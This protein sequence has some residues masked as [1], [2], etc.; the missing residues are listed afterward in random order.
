MTSPGL[1]MVLQFLGHSLPSVFQQE[2]EMCQAQW[3]FDCLSV[4][5]D[6][7]SRSN[8]FPNKRVV[9]AFRLATALV[10]STQEGNGK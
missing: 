3:L 7:T 5:R 8:R 2:L 10:C 6:R 1:K 4:L 9:L